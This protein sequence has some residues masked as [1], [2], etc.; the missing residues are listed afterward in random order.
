MSKIVT[1]R[2]VYNINYK[3]KIEKMKNWA[4]FQ[5]LSAFICSDQCEALRIAPGPGT[6]PLEG[7]LQGV[8]YSC[9]AL[10]STACGLSYVHSPPPDGRW[11]WHDVGSIRE[12]KR[13]SEQEAH[14]WGAWLS[15]TSLYPQPLVLHLHKARADNTFLKLFP[16]FV[17]ILKDRFSKALKRM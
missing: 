15:G 5:F 13:R 16:F 12:H 10:L 17:F 6:P 9:G 7:T 2:V 3:N 8:R 1:S 11:A 14:L 4:H